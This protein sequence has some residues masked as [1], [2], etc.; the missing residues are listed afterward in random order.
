MGNGFALGIA[1]LWNGV[2]DAAREFATAS[3]AIFEVST[4]HNAANVIAWVIMLMVFPKVA[5]TVNDLLNKTLPK[6]F[7]KLGNNGGA[8]GER[9]N[10]AIVI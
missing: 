8:E 4:L 7:M 2:Y 5:Q 6:M 9:V 10:R 3:S 1:G